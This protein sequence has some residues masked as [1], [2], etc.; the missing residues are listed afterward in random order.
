MSAPRSLPG[1][2]RRTLLA[3]AL[4]AA[5]PLAAQAQP[6]QRIVSIGGAVTEIVFALGQEHRLVARDTTSVY[7]AE[8]ELLPDVGYIRQLSPEGVLSVGPDMILTEEGAGPPEAVALLEHAGLPFAVVPNGF[9]TE[10]LQTKVRT[11]GA[12]LGVEAEAEVLAADLGRRMAEAQAEAGAEGIRVLF[13]LSAQGGRVMASGQGTAADAMIGLVGAENA[14]SGFEGYKPL[15]DEAITR[16]APDVILRMSGGGA[17][18]TTGPNTL[19]DNPAVA[20]TPAGQADAFVTMDGM[21][22]L[23]FSIRT[24]EAMHDL[25]TALREAASKTSAPA[26]TPAEEG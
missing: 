8:T 22:M 3:T 7:P 19:L 25:A 2:T 21:Y 9:D 5:L 4:A 16:A 23:G 24:P 11:V 15:T 6:A 14:V 10:A 18:H 13:V 26:Q 12:A 17:D 20:A 1:L